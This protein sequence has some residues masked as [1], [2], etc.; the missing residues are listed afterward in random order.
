M[1]AKHEEEHRTGFAHLFEHLMFSG[2]AFLNFDEP[3][4]EAGG[5]NNALPI[6]ILPTITIPFLPTTL[7][8][9]FV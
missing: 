5:E 6:M 9:R 8:Y 7:K 1:G 2:K 4:Q 3:L